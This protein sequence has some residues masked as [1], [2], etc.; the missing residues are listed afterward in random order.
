MKSLFLFGILLGSSFFAGA[1]NNNRLAELRSKETTD[2]VWVASHRAD[3]VFAPE[4][5]IPALEHA[6]YF[7]A[8]LIETDVR[9]T[10]DGHVV[11]MHDYT[12]DR[13]TNGTGT[14]SEMTLEEIKKLRL[15]TN[16]GGSTDFQVPT[17]EEFIR[18]AKGKACLYLD[19]AGY[20]LPGHEEGYLVKELLKILRGNGV[21]EETVFVLN[22]SYEKAKRIFG[23]DLERVIY[24]PVIEDKIPDLEAYVDEFITKLSPVAFQF[25]FNSLNTDTYRLLPKVLKSGSKAFVAATWDEHTANHSDRVSIFSRPSEGWG[26]LIEQGFRILETNY[27]RDLIRYLELENRHK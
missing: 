15:K 6:I 25:R 27:A 21:L 20:D 7:G 3:Y 16:W 17:L 4:N 5:S 26:W 24:C 9:L 8:D 23:D 12:V 13:M 10:K 19:K 22:W 11:M 14:I 1:Q 18:V 2:Y